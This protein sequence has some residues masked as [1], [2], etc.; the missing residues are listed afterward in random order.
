MRP[1]VVPQQRSDLFL[2]MQ[3]PVD[4]GFE[5]MHMLE[6]GP[7]DVRPGAAELDVTQLQVKGT[8]AEKVK[9]LGILLACVGVA[10]LGLPYLLSKITL[11]QNNEIAMVRAI[12]GEC[13][14]LGSGWHLLDTVTCEIQKASVNSNLVQLGTLTFAR[15]LPGQV[16]MGTLNGH[17]MFLAPGIHLINDPLFKWANSQ[18]MTDPVI[19]VAGTLWMI[20]VQR[21]EVGLCTA[22]FKG[23]F[24]GEGRHIISHPRFKFLGFRS[25]SDE[26]IQVGSKHRILLPAGRLGLAWEGGSALILT[27]KDDNQP[28]YVDSATFRFERSISA[29][30]QVIKHGG[31]KL[32]TVRQGFVGISFR[33]GVLDVLP[34]GRHSLTSPTHAISG[35]LPTGQ[36]TQN[37]SKV[38]S[39]T[40]DNVALEF[41]AA[42]TVQ[43]IDAKKAVITLAGTTEMAAGAAAGDEPEFNPAVVYDNVCRK[44]K[45][46]LTIIMGNQ[47]LNRGDGTEDDD[48]VITQPGRGGVPNIKLGHIAPAEAMAAADAARLGH[49]DPPVMGHNGQAM[50]S[51]PRFMD[52]DGDGIPDAEDPQPNRGPSLKARI[53]DD[54]MADFA[55][56]MLSQ[57]GIAVIDMSVE[58]VRIT[59]PELAAA[60]A[61]GAV[62]RAD[63]A[64]AGIEKQVK[65][66]SSEAEKQSA[67]LA[68]Q[69]K[70]ESTSIIAKAEADRVRVIDEAMASIKAATTQQ[71]EILLA[72]GEVMKAANATMIM[73]QSPGD[74]ASMLA[75]TAAL[76]AMRMA[77]GGSGARAM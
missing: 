48:N 15:V 74:A 73:T 54:F 52:R 50:P 21:G 17:P 24:L 35:F 58:D 28:L 71:R 30:Q 72:A 5:T 53:R 27:P 2:V 29:I 39:L 34:P 20:T 63:L 75:S 44:A 57:C 1:D 10:P 77:N 12:S 70:A 66:T 14:L 67:I 47:R 40:S 19:G 46:A 68:A 59:D 6:S 7:V 45:L 18:S 41:D 55:A 49:S 9:S 16:G 4:E 31:V 3:A 33:D 38:V 62:A 8:A 60:M 76:S 25:A 36:Q 69:G 13:R 42:I 43:V 56:K 37:I 11:V 26:W 64:K 23:H 61:R 22:D 65:L 32:V 51:A